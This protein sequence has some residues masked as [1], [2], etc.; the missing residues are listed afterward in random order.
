MLAHEGD[1]GGVG[2]VGGVEP[3][4]ARERPARLGL[5]FTVRA[6]MLAGTQE[7]EISDAYT[8]TLGL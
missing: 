2:G 8:V 7:S 1:V 4:T 5:Q 6:V 3:E